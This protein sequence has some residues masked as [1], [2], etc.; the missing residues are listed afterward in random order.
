[1]E[2]LIIYDAEG[3]VVSSQ[4]GTP[5]QKEPVG[6]PFLWV[7]IPEKKYVERVDTSTEE[8]KVIFADYP[9]TEIELLRVETAQSNA[10]MFEMILMMSGGGL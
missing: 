3:Y 4:S 8:H 2:T 7:T 9:A 6:I 1:M 5:S 10:E